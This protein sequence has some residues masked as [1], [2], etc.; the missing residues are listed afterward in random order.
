MNLIFLLPILRMQL[1]TS[2]FIYWTVCTVKL[3]KTVLKMSFRYRANKAIKS[4]MECI[5]S[6]ALWR[7]VVSTDSEY[8]NAPIIYLNGLCWWSSRLRNLYGRFRQTFIT[9]TAHGVQ[10][11]IHVWLFDE[12]EE[13]EDPT[14]IRH[15][16]ERALCVRSQSGLLF[17]MS[18]R[19]GITRIRQHW[20]LRFV[21][22]RRK[23]HDRDLGSDAQSPRRWC[24]AFCAQKHGAETSE[25]LIG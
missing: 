15:G 17:F 8:R 20:R 21:D 25:I 13:D 9:A 16:T 24:R 3:A 14:Q 1:S 10:R 5:G 4:I 6:A 22:A 18:E 12:A 2:F 23:I 11:R 7:H 19:S